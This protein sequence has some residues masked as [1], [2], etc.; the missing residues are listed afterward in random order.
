VDDQSV[1]TGT[2]TPA[3]IPDD[4][5]L[6][7]PA[8]VQSD[9]VKVSIL[10]AETAQTVENQNVRV[11][12][13]GREAR[14]EFS[15]GTVYV[16][17]RVRVDASTQDRYSV[18]VEK[19]NERGGGLSIS[20]LENSTY[21][22]PEGIYLYD[23][24]NVTMMAE[25]ASPDRP[26]AL[27]ARYVRTYLDVEQITVS[28]QENGTVVLEGQGTRS[29][30]GTDYSVRATLTEDGVVRRFEAIYTRDG[31]VQFAA[32]SLEPRGVFSVPDWYE[33]ANATERQ[34]GSHVPLQLEIFDTNR[35]RVSAFQ[36]YKPA[37]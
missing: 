27:A 13:D 24:A 32:F 31:R 8:G 5:A 2:V 17:H 14:P 15:L 28:L 20:T 12:F 34:G 29:V 35:L 30:N 1:S 37:N 11:Q 25:R 7:L 21:V 16:G 23:G 4:T 22:T 18:R 33:G 36:R 3:P 9:N 10:A 6:P 26:A 19:V